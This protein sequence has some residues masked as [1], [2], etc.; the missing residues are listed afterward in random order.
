MK[1]VN[2]NV[3]DFEIFFF[4]RLVK[5][6][7]DYLDALLPLAEAYTR[8]GLYEKGLEIDKMIVRLCKKD[9]T[10]YYNLAC[11]YALVGQ[12]RAALQTL[13]QAIEFGYRDFEHLKKDADFK[14]LYEDP[15]FQKLIAGKR[16][17]HS[18]Q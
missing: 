12:N 8:K 1:S 6:K 2:T 3:L 9:S 10:A 5:E 17:K 11:S 16:Q 4:E 18:S 7:P 14:N 13:K 15:E